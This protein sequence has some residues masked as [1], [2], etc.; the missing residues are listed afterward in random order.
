MAGAQII[1]DDEWRLDYESSEPGEHE[2]P[3]AQVTTKLAFDLSHARLSRAV[4]VV[5]A[6]HLGWYMVAAYALITRTIAL[7][8]RPL[9][10]AQSTDAL[11]SFLIVQHGRLA[12]A[13][14]DAS[15]V[16]IIQGWIFA[17]IGAS[18]ASSR[19][20]V[21]LC[22][23]LLIATGFALSQVLG[24]A[25]A[26][27]FAALIAISP[28]IT[29]FSLGGSTAIASLTF[30]MIAIAIAESMRRRPSVIRA[31]GLGVAIAMW[32]TADPI[33]Y[34]TG[35][36]IIV[37]LILVGAVDAVRI[38]H[39]RLRLRV[40]WDRRRVLVI[41][42]AIVAISLWLV[43]TTALFHRPLVPSVEYYFHAAFAP[44]SIAF[45]RA[46]QRL[47]PILIFYE[48]AAVI[49][50]IVGAVAIVS[51]RIGDRFAAWS[52]VWAIVSL[53]TI[54]AVSANGADAVVALVL[55]QALV[56]A[57]AVDWM[58]RSERWNS[59]RYAIV[60]AVALT[61]YVQLAVNFVYPAPDT[62]EA[63]WRRHALLFWSE[64]AT[65]IRTVKECERARNAV[66][67]A[68]ASAMIPDD[69]PQVQ[70]YLRDF[71]QTDSPAGANIVV[72]IGK[73]ESGAVAG[74]PDSPEFG[75]EEWWN[76]DFHKLTVA[77]A[78]EYF[79][80]QRAWSDVEIRNLDI[81]VSK[82]AKE[83]NP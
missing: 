25:G 6:E 77:R 29:Y 41:V 26:L 49:L 53:A 76:P 22:G 37:S 12:Y 50:A 58:H 56:G 61:I 15:W 4:Y 83:H 72:T 7:G 27:A 3:A 11:T 20:V 28:S 78:L 59:I 9:D 14:S 18:D 32:L 40:W 67:P 42:T 47:V 35:A 48:F 73:T 21:T 54:A 10:A 75:F 43:L 34:V 55:P 24:R 81:V 79:F 45:H 62:S 36:A 5:T 82:P 44:P 39:R 46:I 68:G 57:Y 64:P 69:A 16:T 8:A 33:G 63:P 60:A 70:W 74:N 51:R 2:P 23:L 66:S 1:P 52:V 30:M 19:I 38:D 71:T 65:S 80:T 13:L 17:A 31:A